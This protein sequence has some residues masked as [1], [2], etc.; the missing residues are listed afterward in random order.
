MI[1]SFVSIAILIFLLSACS[2]ETK[3]TSES[4]TNTEEG[5]GFSLIPS[6]KS[7]ITFKNNIVESEE[8]NHLTW[9]AFFYGGGVSIGDL[10][11]DGLPDIYFTGNQTSDVIYK[12]LGGLKFQDVTPQLIK[13]EVSWS[14]GVTMADVNGDGLLD[15]YVSK[16]HWGKDKEKVELRKNKLYINKGGMTFSEEAEV[17]GLDNESYSTQASFFDYDGDSDLD[18]FLLNSP[19]NNLQQKV[20]YSC[21]LRN[22]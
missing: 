22:V 6:A 10:D 1:K 21:H 3:T 11:D 18:V 19:S 20:E 17:F 16:T 5:M 13:E 12:N 7:G 15:I 2:E 14:N 8:L 9:D 4:T